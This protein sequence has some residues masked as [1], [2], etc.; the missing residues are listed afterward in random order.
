MQFSHKVN[1]NGTI[2]LNMR[3][4]KRLMVRLF[5]TEKL[6]ALAGFISPVKLTIEFDDLVIEENWDGGR[7]Q[8]FGGL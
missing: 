1:E 7:P 2:S 5:L 4:Y 6:L 3:G 8:G